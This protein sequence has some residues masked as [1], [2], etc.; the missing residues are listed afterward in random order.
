MRITVLILTSISML[1]WIYFLILNFSIARDLTEF[2]SLNISEDGIFL[3]TPIVGALSTA[4]LG[5]V[6]IRK[7]GW[8]KVVLLFLSLLVGSFLLIV[9]MASR[10]G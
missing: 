1:I 2:R 6:S 10:A 7:V 8:A 4:L 3:G 9:V 5:Y